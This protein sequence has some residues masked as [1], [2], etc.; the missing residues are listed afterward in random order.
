MRELDALLMRAEPLPWNRIRFG[1]PVF[2]L[3]RLNLGDGCLILVTHAE[4]HFAQ[5]DRVLAESSGG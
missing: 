4:R 3:L 5:I 2:A 1:S